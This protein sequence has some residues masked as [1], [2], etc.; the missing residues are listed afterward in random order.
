SSTGARPKETRS[1][2]ESSCLP[3][4]DSTSQSLAS[5][6][7]RASTPPAR[8][9]KA[10]APRRYPGPRHTRASTTTNPKTILSRVSRLGSCFSST[11]SFMNSFPRQLDHFPPGDEQCAAQHHKPKRNKAKH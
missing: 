4:S 11:L 7:S 5:F 9:I 2:K 10:Q 1:A 8:R 3:K 6:P